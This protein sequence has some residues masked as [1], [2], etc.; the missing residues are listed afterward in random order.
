MNAQTQSPID[1]SL[2]RLVAHARSAGAPEPVAE[3][4]RKATAARFLAQGRPGDVSPLRMESYFWGVVR[5]RA[6]SGGAPAIA[7]LIVAASLAAELGDAGR[8]SGV[9]ARAA[10]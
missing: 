2:Q 3:E 6:L 9:G 7:R 5:R 8:S 4:A 1:A 10:I